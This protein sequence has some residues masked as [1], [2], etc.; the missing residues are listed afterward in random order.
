MYTHMNPVA[1]VFIHLMWH[2][3]GTLLHL[4][5]FI[6]I[7]N[8]SRQLDLT[9]TLLFSNELSISGMTFLSLS[10]VQFSFRVAYIS[11][12]YFGSIKQLIWIF[13]TAVTNVHALDDVDGDG[14]EK[15]YKAHNELHRFIMILGISYTQHSFRHFFHSTRWSV[16]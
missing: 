11:L 8:H 14:D 12:K 15:H 7:G 13:S 3:I 2:F 4:Y 6:F 9:W 16:Y 5:L 10:L 1:G